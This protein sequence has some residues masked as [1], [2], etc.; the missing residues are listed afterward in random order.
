MRLIKAILVLGTAGAWHP[1]QFPMAPMPRASHLHACSTRN[2]PPA[3]PPHETQRRHGGGDEGLLL[4][5]MTEEER[6]ALVQLWRWDYE[7]SHSAEGEDARAAS[8]IANWAE[9]HQRPWLSVLRP[10]SWRAGFGP[11]STEALI[12]TR[13]ELDTSHWQRALAGEHSTCSPSSR[14][15]SHTLPAPSRILSQYRQACARRRPD[16]ALAQRTIAPSRRRARRRRTGIRAVRRVP[17]SKGEVRGARLWHLRELWLSAHRGRHSCAELRR[18]GRSPD[19]PSS[20]GAGTIIFAS[21]PVQRRARCV[22]H[23]RSTLPGTFVH[24]EV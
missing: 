7:L 12:V 20:Q 15:H 11:G 9:E 8:F 4:A 5:S 14:L 10:R 16:S 6:Q 24:G 22:Q 23:S 1:M 13:Y 17:R 3:P 19:D 18:P 21:E 2:A